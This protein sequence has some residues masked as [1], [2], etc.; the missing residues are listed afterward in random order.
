MGASRVR[1]DEVLYI[2]GSTA[3]GYQNHACVQEHHNFQGITET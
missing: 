1:S 3:G 2:C